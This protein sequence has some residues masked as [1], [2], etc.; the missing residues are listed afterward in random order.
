M[1]LHSRRQ[2][3]LNIPFCTLICFINELQIGPLIRQ[4]HC[5]TAALCTC[6][7]VAAI[8][9]IC[10]N[11]SHRCSPCRG[12]ERQWKDWWIIKAHCLCKGVVLGLPQPSSWYCTSAEKY[13]RDHGFGNRAFIELW[14][15]TLGYSYFFCWECRIS[16]RISL[17]V[18]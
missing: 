4:L 3:T 18:L 2:E 10:A 5:V 6:W 11:C 9:S 1:A 17:A 8:N 15:S 16:I 13:V 12:S 7:S 14:S